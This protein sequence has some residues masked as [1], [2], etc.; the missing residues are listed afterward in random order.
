M[1]RSSSAWSCGVKETECSIHIAYIQ[2]IGEAK[3]FIYIEN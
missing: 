3:H 1:V 2:L